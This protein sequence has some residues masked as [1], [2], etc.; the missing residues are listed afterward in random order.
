MWVLLD[1]GQASVNI[2]DMSQLVHAQGYSAE[3]LAFL[4]IFV[5]MVQYG[6][7]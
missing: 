3:E 1:A 6:K 5:F 4:E 2:T 7:A